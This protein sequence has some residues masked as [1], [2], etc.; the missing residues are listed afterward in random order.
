MHGA[1][2]PQHGV[3][4]HDRV[5]FVEGDGRAAGGRQET[6][7]RLAQLVAEALGAGIH[8]GG[9][10]AARLARPHEDQELVAADAGDGHDVGRGER[11]ALGLQRDQGAGE[12]TEKPVVFLPTPRRLRARLRGQVEIDDPQAAPLLH[13]PAYVVHHRG[14]GGQP[15]VGVEDVVLEAE[16][17]GPQAEEIRLLRVGRLHLSRAAFP[18]PSTCPNI[19][20][21]LASRS[22]SENGLQM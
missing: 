5:P 18:R 4:V 7:Q 17:L 11:P 16:P 9:V 12:R 10:D 13:E 21:I 19:V 14:Q 8:G 15:G 2:G 1:L 20:S 3:A 22:W 6:R